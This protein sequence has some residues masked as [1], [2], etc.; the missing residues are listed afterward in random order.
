MPADRDRPSK[1]PSDRDRQPRP[2][3]DRDRPPR[4]RP[5]HRYGQNHLVDRGVLE[6]ILRQAAVRP[7]D[8]VLEVGAADGLLTR[9]LLEQ[10][11][12]VHA[13]EVDRR[14]ASRLERLAAG[15]PGLHVHLE[16]ALK[17]RLGELDPAPT[18]LV[19]NLAYNIAIPLVMTT[20]AQ[21]PSI[22]RWA[23][24]VQKELGERLF[25]VPGTKAYAAV[26]V[27]TQFNCELERARPVARSAFRPRPNVESAFISFARRPVASDG[28]WLVGAQPLDRDG[29]A[30]V[31]RLVRRAFA[32]RRKQ[33]ATSLSGADPGAPSGPGAAPAGG[34]ALG[35]AD[36]T[37]AL[38]AVSAI[39]TARPEELDPERW[40]AFAR[41]LGWLTTS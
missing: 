41:A 21:V 9:P 14:Y 28:A 12:V 16:D 33:L 3:S 37:R 15:A 18:A 38:E 40:L 8:V 10:A 5:L 27:L 26:S 30:V 1:P 24:M 7:D 11:S 2:P 22:R 29:Y 39:A 20:V 34:R 13:F 23:I 31:E 6:A 25:A 4:P 17:A 36:V 19:A 32:Q 35:R